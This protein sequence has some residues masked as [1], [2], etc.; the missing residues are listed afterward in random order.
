[1]FD[2]V[3]E[4]FVPVPGSKSSY[5]M[6]ISKICQCWKTYPDMFVAVNVTD[7]FGETSI[8][9]LCPLFTVYVV[10]LYVAVADAPEYVDGTVRYTL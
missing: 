8:V 6:L 10:P 4:W 2:S 3:N 5:S 1:M 9:L 7:E